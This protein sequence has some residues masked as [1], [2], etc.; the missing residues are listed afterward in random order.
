MNL[1]DFD[2]T[3]AMAEA[4][5]CMPLQVLRVSIDKGVPFNILYLLDQLVR[6]TTLEALEFQYFEGKKNVQ[7][8]NEIFYKVMAFKQVKRIS[9]Y[10]TSI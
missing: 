1:P 7:Y 4:I 10:G 5:N 8:E 9:F 6:I 3:H 2:G